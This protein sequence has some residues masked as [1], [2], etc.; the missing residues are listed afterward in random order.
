MDIDD[1]SLNAEDLRSLDS[2]SCNSSALMYNGLHSSSVDLCKSNDVSSK[3][4]TN[5]LLLKNGANCGTDIYNR[6][7]SF[8]FPT[9]NLGDLS[10]ALASD[11]SHTVCVKSNSDDN[12]AHIFQDGIEDSMTSMDSNITILESYFSDSLSVDSPCLNYSY[13]GSKKLRSTIDSDVKIDSDGVLSKLLDFDANELDTETDVQANL[14]SH[15]NI[16]S[17]A[18]TDANS[19]SSCVLWFP[20]FF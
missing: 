3:L 1:K 13:R 18:N 10:I 2:F 7:T 15:N 16:Q 17:F 6:D 9:R 12:S 19:Q 20:S 14:T 5:N 4:T 11:K 8:S